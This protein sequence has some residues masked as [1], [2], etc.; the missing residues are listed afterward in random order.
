MDGLVFRYLPVE[1]VGHGHG[2]AF[3]TTGAARAFVLIH[4][5]GPFHQGDGKIAGP[6]L[7]RFHLGHGQDFDIGVAFALQKFGRF[8]THGAVI[9]GKGLV[10]LGHLAADG[11]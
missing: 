8:N 4:I 5:P 6:A 7:N 3:R 11:G 2:A 10:E 9:G 1:G